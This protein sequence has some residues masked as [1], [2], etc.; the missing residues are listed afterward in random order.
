[1]TDGLC[2]SRGLKAKSRTR[3][4]F[5]NSSSTSIS[6]ACLV[7]R[8]HGGARTRLEFRSR[9]SFLTPVSLRVTP[10]FSNQGTSSRTLHHCLGF[11]FTLMGSSNDMPT[12]HPQF[13][14]EKE[15]PSRRCGTIGAM[16][17]IV[18]NVL[19]LIRSGKL[20]A[21]N[22][23]VRFNFENYKIAFD[24]SFRL[25]MLILVACHYA[26]I[27]N[28]TNFLLN[29]PKKLDEKT[30]A[31]RAKLV[32]KVLNKKGPK[33]RQKFTQQEV[34]SAIRRVTSL[35]LRERSD[36][37]VNAVGE[38]ALAELSSVP[39]PVPVPMAVCKQH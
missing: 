10:T 14:A 33:P 4:R 2:A 17:D 23:N 5:G 24:G 12:R 8:N 38:T 18:K 29:L 22:G 39:V 13:S 9:R 7:P 27:L 6:T 32:W 3:G 15:L 36:R 26:G 30:F 16:T 21:E 28:S 31:R 25:H 1:M 19:L 20:V 35:I 37:I 11:P 34:C